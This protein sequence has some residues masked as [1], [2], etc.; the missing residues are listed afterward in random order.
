MILLLCAALF[1]IPFVRASLP[2][3]NDTHIITLDASGCPSCNTRTV[4]D[5]LSS[6]GLTLFACTWTAIHPDIPGRD[7]WV[8]GTAFRRLILML[9]AFA[10]PEFVVGWAIVQF[11]HARQVAK[12]FN[13]EFGVGLAQPCGWLRAMLRGGSTSTDDG[14]TLTHGFFACMGGFMLCVDNKPRVTL[15]PDELLQFVRDGSVE[16]PTIT[17]AEIQDQ[18]KGDMPA[19]CLAICHLVWFIFQLIARYIQKL[20]VTLLE[21][22]TLGVVV[23]TCI[24]YGFWL[25]KPKNVRLPHNVH[26]KH[27]STPLPNSLNSGAERDTL[28]ILKLLF[29][30]RLLQSILTPEHIILCIGCVSGIIFG[31]IHCLGWNVFFP[32]HTEQVLWR[33]ASIWIPGMLL[34]TALQYYL[35]KF[36]L[37][38]TPTAELVNGQTSESLPSPQRTI[39]IIRP[40]L[41]VPI[42]S[43]PP[44]GLFGANLAFFIIY[45]V[46]ARMTIIVLMF[47][48][49]RSLPPGAYDTVLWT[50]FIP[51]ANL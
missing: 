38:S 46:S 14:W 24:S 16:K 27:P 30:S 4:W 39:D 15:E 11:F 20:P 42:R 31:G 32:K 7:E 2:G 50:Q 22:D 1:C 37:K 3:L 41:R 45:Y 13:N 44:G 19:K 25:F 12:D 6:C 8:A 35:L 36:M 33:V 26:W 5:I 10:A 34:L 9:A 18:S 49:L 51:H 21:I 47:L 23:M 40:I 48:S 29:N 17:Q 43:Q 28:S